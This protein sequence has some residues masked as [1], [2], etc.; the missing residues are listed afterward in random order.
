MVLLRNRDKDFNRQ[1]I[2]DNVDIPE[3]SLGPV[4][5]RLKE[6]GLIRHKSGY[7]AIGK[8]DRLAAVAA[9]A[10]ASESLDERLGTE[11]REEWVYT[12]DS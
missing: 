9:K 5:T 10:T 7:W 3:N 8:D 2:Q 6:L 11:D 12:E 1:E 4:L